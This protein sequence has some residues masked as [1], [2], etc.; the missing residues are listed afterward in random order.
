MKGHSGQCPGSFRFCRS[1]L[2][3]QDFTGPGSYGGACCIVFV[4]NSLCTQE[5]SQTLMVTKCLKA[6]MEGSKWKNE[7]EARGGGWENGSSARLG[8]AQRVFLALT[9]MGRFIYRAPIKLRGAPSLYISNWR[10]GQPVAIA[11]LRARPLLVSKAR[12]PLSSQALFFCLVLPG[13]TIEWIVTQGKQIFFWGG[14]DFSHTEAN[15]NLD[16]LATSQGTSED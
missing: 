11:R 13:S 16:S 6:E 10:N 15:Q 5:C 9:A 3:C 7:P 2:T 14:P 12:Q 1:G 4:Q 8:P